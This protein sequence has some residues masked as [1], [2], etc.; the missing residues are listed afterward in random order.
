MTRVAAR[1]MRGWLTVLRE[2]RAVVESSK[3]FHVAE[4]Y[5]PICMALAT[6]P[7]RCC[8]RQTDNARAPGLPHQLTFTQDKSSHIT[9]AERMRPNHV[10]CSGFCAP[11]CRFQEGDLGH[12]RLTHSVLSSEDG[13]GICSGGPQLWQTYAR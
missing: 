6:A 13:Q 10:P 2:L 7:L 5:L 9:C 11:F 12:V 8:L 1:V 3:R 4:S